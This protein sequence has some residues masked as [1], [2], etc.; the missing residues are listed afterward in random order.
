[1]NAPSG[2]VVPVARATAPS[3]MSNA[4]PVVA[5]MPARSHSSN[6]ARTPPVDAIAKP[7]RV[8]MFGVSPARAIASATGSMRARIPLRVSGETSGSLAHR[9]ARQPEQLVLV[10]VEA[11]GAT[12]RERL[13]MTSRPER[14]V[15]TRPAVRRR[16]RCHE[17][18]GCERSTWR[19]RS[20]TVPS[21]CARRCDEAQARR[22]GQGLVDDRDVMEVGWR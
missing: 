2:L 7:M 5:T 12:S 10:V 15:S 14:R 20:V 6:A 17:T 1:M 18:S 16:R 9:L 4:A 8:S 3:N 11:G 13:Q 21:P 22:I 19:M